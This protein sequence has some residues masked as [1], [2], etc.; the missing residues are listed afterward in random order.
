MIPKII[1][2][3]VNSE[4]LSLTLTGLIPLIIILASLKGVSITE[5]ELGVAVEMAVGVVSA[6]GVLIT[7]T[8]TLYGFSRKIAVKF[9]QK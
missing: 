4:K 7:A 8:M 6:V 9:Q 1:Q 2:S 3:S 5:A